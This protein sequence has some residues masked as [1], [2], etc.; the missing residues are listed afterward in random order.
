MNL[1][2]CPD[3]WMGRR[4]GRSTQLGSCELS[5]PAL[6]I[7]FHW[8]LP[9]RRNCLCPPPLSFWQ[10]KRHIPKQIIMNKKSFVQ[11]ISYTA[12]PLLKNNLILGMNPPRLCSRLH[13]F[14]RSW[15]PA[16][17]SS[18]SSEVQWVEK[19]SWALQ[20]RPVLGLDKVHISSPWAMV[21]CDFSSPCYSQSKL[22]AVAQ[23]LGFKA[24]L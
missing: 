4:P 21:W 1:H 6:V 22:K 11:W 17:S 14:W 13:P 12:V 5:T 15:G 18:A 9:L 2:P 16:K 23:F 19:M 3:T 10:V 24:H 20:T 8:W 7:P